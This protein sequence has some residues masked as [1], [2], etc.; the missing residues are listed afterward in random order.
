MDRKPGHEC[1][2]QMASL[3]LVSQLQHMQDERC[4]LL[5]GMCGAKSCCWLRKWGHQAWEPQPPASPDSCVCILGVLLG[6][7]KIM[8]E[9]VGLLRH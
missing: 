5:R 2:A 3:G 4:T 8:Q 9:Q 1:E 6:L 7:A